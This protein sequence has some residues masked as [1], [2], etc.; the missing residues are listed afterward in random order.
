[1]TA[2]NG[3]DNDR[4]RRYNVRKQRVEPGRPNPGKVIT[5]NLPTLR[6]D[7][8]ALDMY[9]DIHPLEELIEVMR[10]KWMLVTR[11]EIP[12]WSKRGKL[13]EYGWGLLRG[14]LRMDLRQSSYNRK[15]VSG[16]R[17]EDLAQLKSDIK[18]FAA[19]MGYICGFTKIDRRFIARGADWKFP[20]DTAIVLGMEM[21]RE[22]LDQAPAPG[23]KLFDFEVYVESGKRVFDVA[24]F[25]R[26]RGYKCHA[27][28]PAD[29]WIKYPPHAINAGL[30]ELGAMGVVVTREYGPR[31]RWTMISIDA[32]I[33]IDEPV[34][35]NM[36]AYCDDC[37]LCIKACPGKA[38]TEELIWWRG[39]YKRKNRD[40]K[41][42]PYFVK[43]DGCGICLK[44]CPIHRHGYDECMEA[45]RKDGT[46][47]GRK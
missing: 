35:L 42:W 3:A 7:P 32:D 36:A 12:K 9:S 1:M 10:N 2:D 27:R 16:E 5:D 11:M 33:E 41:C 25:I 22:L 30:G 46:I 34:D 23:D 45:Y 29:G 26:S 15:L 6:I 17:E 37:K 31:I 39:V 38:I 40:L 4:P 14:I 20:Y 13:H 18:A 43:Y 47:L 19:D 28:I 8:Q 21:D 44:V 24:D